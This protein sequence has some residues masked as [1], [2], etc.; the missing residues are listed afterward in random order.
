MVRIGH[1]AIRDA[2]PAEDVVVP[3]AT[4]PV[5][6]V[7]LNDVPLRARIRAHQ[8]NAVIDPGQQVCRDHAARSL[9]ED[10]AEFPR[11]PFCRVPG[12]VGGSLRIAADVQPVQGDVRGVLIRADEV[13]FPLQR[14]ARPDLQV[15]EHQIARPHGDQQAV[16]LRL[17]AGLRH[18]RDRRVEDRPLHSDIAV[19]TALEQQRIAARH[20]ARREGRR[21]RREGKPL[22]AV[23]RAC[24]HRPERGHVVSPGHGRTG[25]NNPQYKGETTENPAHERPQFVSLL[26]YPV[27]ALTQECAAGA[28]QIRQF[29]GE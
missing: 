23:G 22:A 10:C 15:A 24:G 29:R 21:D 20:L 14:I 12:H 2:V 4:Q 26:R 27:Q 1:D 18:D 7:A 13:K 16:E 17:L 11:L 8:Q 28:L 3:G 25:Q 6:I 19:G 9:Q 5:T